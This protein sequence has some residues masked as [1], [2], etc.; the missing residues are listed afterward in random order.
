MDAEALWDLFL[1]T[2]APEIYI[3]YKKSLRSRGQPN[4]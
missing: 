1:L 2:G 3:L 4:A